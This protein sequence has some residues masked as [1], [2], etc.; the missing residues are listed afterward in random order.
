MGNDAHFKVWVDKLGSHVE[1]KPTAKRIINSKDMHAI[2][3]GNVRKLIL[4]NCLS[5][6]VEQVYAQ[7]EGST[8]S[9]VPFAS[10]IRHEKLNHKHHY[11]CQ[12][13]AIENDVKWY[14]G[15]T[16]ELKDVHGGTEIIS[17]GSVRKLI[18]KSEL[19]DVRA[20]CG[21][22]STSCSESKLFQSTSIHTTRRI[23]DDLSRKF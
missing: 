8:V 13:S 7:C 11:S 14:L 19:V 2:A 4:K 9:F 16:D 23:P 15:A 5:Q 10:S 1:W 18:S 6:D 3:V 12:V 22:L 21:G 17:V 20:V